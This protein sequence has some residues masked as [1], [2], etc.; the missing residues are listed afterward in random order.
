M[1][2]FI[3][4][5]FFITFTN[6]LHANCLSAGTAGDDVVNCTGATSGHQFFLGGSDNVTLTNVT[7]SAFFWLD[8]H[9]YGDASTDKKD[10]FYA[11]DSNFEWIFA[12][13]DDDYFEIN[14]SNFNNLYADT[15][16][17][18]VDQH[19]DDRIIMRN[20]TSHGYIQGG[21]DSDTITLIDCNVSNIA[22]GYSNIIDPWNWIGDYTPYDGNDT[23]VLDHVNFTVPLYWDLTQIEGSL[24]TGKGDDSITFL[25]GGEVYYVYGGHGSDIIEIFDG[26]HFNYCSNSSQTTDVC[27]IYGDETYESELNASQAPLLHG[28]DRILVHD[29]IL[30]QIL[31][32]AGDGSDYL[33]LEQPVSI[34]A[35]NLNGGDDI[36]IADGFVDRVQFEQWV[37]DLNGSQFANWEQVHLHNASSITMLDNN[38]TAGSD[39]GTDAISGLPYGIIIEDNSQLNIYHDFIIKA[40]LNNDATLNLQDGNTPGAK[41]TIEN[42][43]A[44]SDGSIYLDAVLNNGLP[45]ITDK[46]I[47]SEN[48]Y[49]TTLLYIEN[50][51]G[52][53]GDTASG[54][55][56][57]VIEVLG[58]SNAIFKLGN[59]LETNDYWYNLQKKLDGNWYL[60]SS[61][62]AGSLRIAIDTNSTP[63]IAGDTLSYTFT[64]VNTGN[65]DLNDT[66]LSGTNC[67]S[68]PILISESNISDGILQIGET[69]TYICTSVS[70]TQDEIDNGTVS[71]E[72]NVTAIGLNGTNMP[73]SANGTLETEITWSSPVAIRDTFIMSGYGST[74]SNIYANDQLFSCNPSETTFVIIQEPQHGTISLDSNGS[75]TYTPHIDF[76]GVDTVEYQIICSEKGI[77]SNIA[78]LGITVTSCGCDNITSDSISSLN[79]FGILGMIISILVL[80]RTRREY[81]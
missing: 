32:Q 31:V 9:A 68:T 61:L 55:D 37:G 43:Y 5:V 71:A 59:T 22:S 56:I 28:D 15:N 79:I 50:I 54:N 40:N 10:K 13:G 23:V 51:A 66:A 69:Q 73:I 74:N 46:L 27:G 60:V 7:G 72:V 33:L 58:N 65:I 26:V 42:N 80:I 48:S 19:G 8:Q 12:F 30:D 21:N 70:I 41:L 49:G 1:K 16:P 25:H 52:A 20:S 36:S 47:I 24:Y 44:S 6:I 35:T 39:I 34:K 11:T 57:M 76:Q 4:L 18:V 75:Y 38:I 77:K 2:K 63:S 64:I 29:A 14:G 45:N 67:S 53:G 17:P 3:F 81:I 78:T 62:K